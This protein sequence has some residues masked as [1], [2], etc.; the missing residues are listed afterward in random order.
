[1][2]LTNSPDDYERI[3]QLIQSGRCDSCVAEMVIVGVDHARLAAG[4]TSRWHLPAAIIAGVTGHH[5]PEQ[6]GE[7][8]PLARVVACADRLA[9][10][11]AG[12][13]PAVLVP[14]IHD[15]LARLGLEFAAAEELLRTVL[16]HLS[17]P[18]ELV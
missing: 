5:D 16:T 12:D 14:E 10:L 18:A 8:V 1:M 4:L 15:D 3:Q 6:A 7:H 17:D 9:R 11:H 2:I 13:D